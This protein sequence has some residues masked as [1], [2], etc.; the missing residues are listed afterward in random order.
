MAKDMRDM[1]KSLQLAIA[2]VDPHDLPALA[3]AHSRFSEIAHYGNVS[4][5]PAIEHA[6]L[7][8]VRRLEAIV[9]EEI[10]GTQAELG[11]LT[12]TLTA[13]RA[14]LGGVPAKNAAF[15]ASITQSIEEGTRAGAEDVISFAQ[16]YRPQIESLELHLLALETDSTDPVA[17]RKI[18][19][20]LIGVESH[21]KALGLE[22]WAAVVKP[23][24][25]IVRRTEHGEL[26]LEGA[27]LEVAFDAAALLLRMCRVAKQGLPTFNVEGFEETTDNLYAVLNGTLD[28]SASKAET[29]TEQRLGD[30]L[31]EGGVISKPVLEEALAH[32]SEE[33]LRHYQMGELL[34]QEGII[35]AETLAQA[36]D[37]QQKNPELGRLGDMLVQMGA[38]TEDE[39]DKA[40]ETQSE[41]SRHRLGEVLVRDRKAAA[42]DVG[43]VVR[44][45]GFL[46]TLMQFGVGGPAETAESEEEEIYERLCDDP[47]V[48]QRFAD[49]CRTQ[50]RAAELQ[51]LAIQSSEK[52][53]D[54][55]LNTIIRIFH[56]VKRVSA[57]IGLETLEAYTQAAERLFRKVRSRDIDMEGPAL[58]AGLEAVAVIQGHI[59]R[60]TAGGEIDESEIKDGIERI[61][62]LAA[63]RRANFSRVDLQSVSL[64]NQRLG[65]LL[66]NAGIVGEDDIQSLL[67]A[68][69]GSKEAKRLGDVL[70]D[71]GLVTSDQ[72]EEALTIQKNSPDRGRLG[73]IL[74]QIGAIDSDSL[75]SAL[76]AQR[77]ESRP[78]LGELLVRAGKASSQDV[79]RVVRTQNFIK[80]LIAF[81]VTTRKPQEDVSSQPEMDL[82]RDFVDRAQ[83]HLDAADINLLR[84]E[85]D[86]G[87][88]LALD[89]VRRA[90]LG[91][92][93]ISG[94]VGLDAIH[95]YTFEFEKYLDAVIDGTVKLDG[96]VVDFTFDAVEVLSRHIAQIQ[97]QLQTGERPKGDSGLEA[98][99]GR[100]RALAS[101]NT[102]VLRGNALAPSAFQPKRLGELLVD[103]GAISNEQL[104]EVLSSQ[105]SEPEAKKLGEL[106]LDEVRV[107][108]AQL[109]TALEIQAKDPSLKLGDI[110]VS[111]GAIDPRE[112]EDLLVQ[113]KRQGRARLGELIVRKGFA[114]AKTVAR[115]VRDQR[116]ITNLVRTGATAAVVGVAIASPYA[117]ADDATGADFSG[118]SVVISV[119]AGADGGLDTDADGLSDAV[120]KSMGTDL[121]SADT[122]KDGI[123]D[124]WE[125]ING[126]DPLNAADANEDID[127]DRLTNLNEFLAG[128]SPFDADTDMDGYYDG[129]ETERGTDATAADSFPSSGVQGDVNADGE[130][131][132]SDVQMVINAALGLE[133][134]AP[135][136]VDNVEGVNA[137]DVQLVIANSLK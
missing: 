42:K 125:V 117:A 22:E 79:A 89:S 41:G 34:V 38:V 118:G 132:S 27:N 55:A 64:D 110:L 15:P 73:D 57:C 101:G 104:Q 31:V 93:R 109:D 68:Q 39:I 98:Y 123:D 133:V 114:S 134:E 108:Q 70:A 30:A 58:D 23:L 65:E 136:N 120:E 62:S 122:D 82:V 87:N 83:K 44:K 10:P 48:M 86:P 45:Q 32:Q 119:T 71:Q 33:A 6:A 137:L 80:D 74:V 4:G 129:L 128:T 60:L 35:S 53:G 40:F 18:N 19:T 96:P 77:S 54:A 94:Y 11:I 106:L 8:C 126:L 28:T 75:G 78:R 81:G 61:K 47:E 1:L 13:M 20:S 9:L 115:A 76:D 12:D 36:V 92:K 16:R 43:K 46:R 69:A 113:Q 99:R 14:V 37:L 131:D 63:G 124:A 91:I 66:V 127:G 97:L 49:R 29:G 112:L 121:N 5:K 51:L 130:V 59:D 21:A 56:N 102:S 52:T 17:I 25:E 24:H 85:E 107:S 88:T 26:D 2:E 103:S 67:D 72:L 111:I 100:M 116:L 90:I 84:L 50:L 7:A 135:G 105:A 95:A 3:K